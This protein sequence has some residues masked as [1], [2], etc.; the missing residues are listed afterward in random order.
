MAGWG[1]GLMTDITD[2]LMSEAEE[3]LYSFTGLMPN[4]IVKVINR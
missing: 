4:E 1:G 2:K 3:A